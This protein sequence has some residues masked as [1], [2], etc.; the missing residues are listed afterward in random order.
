LNDNPPEANSQLPEIQK[1]LEELKS[2]FWGLGKN[3]NSNHN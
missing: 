1:D 3:M 2:D